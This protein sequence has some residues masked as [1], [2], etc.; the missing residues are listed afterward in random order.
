MAGTSAADNTI[1]SGYSCQV[2][3]GMPVVKES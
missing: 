1:S 3:I 2:G